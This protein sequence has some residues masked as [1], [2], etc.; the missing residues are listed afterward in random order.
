ML[1]EKGQ[2]LLARLACARPD[3]DQMPAILDREQLHFWHRARDEL[4][5]RERHIPIGAPMQHQRWTG[6][7]FQRID[8]QMGILVQ[9]IQRMSGAARLDEALG[10]G[11]LEHQAPHPFGMTQRELQRRRLRRPRCL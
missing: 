3:P 1:P 9:I 4:G 8:R 10:D 11:G 2:D 7:L 5:V 6:N